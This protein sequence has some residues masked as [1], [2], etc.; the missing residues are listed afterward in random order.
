MYTFHQYIEE[1]RLSSIPDFQKPG[2]LMVNIKE[3]LVY[4]KE[5][6]QLIGFVDLDDISNQAFEKSLTDSA[7]KSI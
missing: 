1:A 7:S 6:C 5:E 4:D 3:G 2:F